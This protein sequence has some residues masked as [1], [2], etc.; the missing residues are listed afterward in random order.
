MHR[1]Y[2][3]FDVST[4]VHVRSYSG[5]NVDWSL[6]RKSS[7]GVVPF[8]RDFQLSQIGDDNFNSLGLPGIGV[9]YHLWIVI[10]YGSDQQD[11]PG[12][13]H[14]GGSSYPT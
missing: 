11:I 1:I 2:N 10:I 4:R 8:S 7:E 13:R 3:G 6:L 9:S 5:R 12:S 14:P